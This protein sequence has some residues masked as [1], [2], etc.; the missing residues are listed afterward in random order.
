MSGYQPHK[1][2]DVEVGGMK[3]SRI[4]PTD[5]K[6]LRCKLGFHNHIYFELTDKQ[7]EPYVGYSTLSGAQF[8]SYCERCD[9]IHPGRRIPPRPMPPVQPPKE[10]EKSE[11]TITEEELDFIRALMQGEGEVYTFVKQ[12]EPHDLGR[13]DE[14]E[15]KK[16]HDIAEIVSQVHTLL[17]DYSTQGLSSKE[18]N[19]VA[20]L[21]RL[22]HRYNRDIKSNV[23]VGLLNAAKVGYDVSELDKLNR[24]KEGAVALMSKSW[25]LRARTD[26]RILTRYVRM[27]E[28]KFASLN[29]TPPPPKPPTPPG[30]RI[31]KDGKPTS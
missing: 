5:P 24:D 1:M 16:S 19:D 28:A 17:R 2:I 26:D 13:W 23:F 22:A 7:A 21:A 15:R 10:E 27:A 3:L 31:I 20:Y 14:E 9:E 4:A 30:P 12:D 6:S 29:P 11:Q 25:Q 8:P 18:V